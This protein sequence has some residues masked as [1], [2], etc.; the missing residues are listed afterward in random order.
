MKRLFRI[1]YQVVTAIAALLALTAATYA[2]FTSN[3]SVSTSTAVTRTGDQTLELQISEQGEGAFQSVETA[4]ISQVNGTDT[5]WL[6]P[7]STADLASFVYSPS[8]VD[9]QAAYF[10]PVTDESNYFHGRIYVRAVGEGWP[11][12]TVMNL[13]LDQSGGILGEAVEGQLLKCGQTG[14]EI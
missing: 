8:T 7:V 12:G 2:W 9:G 5:G 14:T 11:Q 3:K 6:M 13:Y 10:Q 1:W 4:S